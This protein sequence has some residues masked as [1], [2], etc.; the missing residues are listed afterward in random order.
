MTSGLG[1]G[2][3]TMTDPSFA[4]LV[5]RAKE[6][7][8]DAIRALLAQFED[9]VRLA[10]RRRLP[11]ILRTKFDSMDFVQTVWASIFVD[12]GIDPTRFES[13]QHLLAYLMGVAGN[14]VREEYRRRTVSRKYDVR[15]EEPLYLR[16]S[17][18][19]EPREV[20]S[21]APTASADFRGRER[22]EALLKGRSERER[23]I[24]RLRYEGMT[25]AEIAVRTGLNEKTARRL[26]EDLRRT[27]LGED[28]A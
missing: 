3:T 6:G 14:K 12:G 5:R 23:E 7:D 18:R 8:E 16:R 17:G 10:V 24:V 27:Q 15:R 11:K 28:S 2:V 26:I 25:F 13:R 22:L 1:L 20:A 9:E 4:E 19:D 21:V